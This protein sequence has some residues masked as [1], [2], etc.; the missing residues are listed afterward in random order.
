MKNQDKHPARDW[1]FIL[2]ICIPTYSRATLLQHTLDSIIHES[3]FQLHEVEVVISDNVSKDNTE[4]I[5]KRYVNQYPDR[6]R[7][8]RHDAPIDPHFN[9]EYALNMGSGRFLKLNNDNISFLPGG[10]DRLVKDLEEY[11]SL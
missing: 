8:H 1:D 10:L 4:E 3:V 2:S 7:Y 9:Y 5:A 11:E 6:I